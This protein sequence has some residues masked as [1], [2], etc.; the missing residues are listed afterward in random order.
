MIN[1]KERIT[2]SI[3]PNLLNAIDLYLEK[4]GLGASRS[5]LIEDSLKQYLDRQ[6]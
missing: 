2:I 1:H 3:N 5:G 4:I 6:K